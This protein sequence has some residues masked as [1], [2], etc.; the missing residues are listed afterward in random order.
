MVAQT[1]AGL[2]P[3]TFDI[4]AHLSILPRF[5][6]IWDGSNTHWSRIVVRDQTAPLATTA[7]GACEKHDPEKR[8]AVFRK[9]HAQSRI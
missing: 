7:A 5:A 3:E 9:D 1:T 4:A 6:V 2:L 8:A